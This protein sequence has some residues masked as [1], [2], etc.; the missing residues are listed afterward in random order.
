MLN[1]NEDLIYLGGIE[2]IER[3]KVERTA[4]NEY[5]MDSAIRDTSVIEKAE[6]LIREGAEPREAYEKAIKLCKQIAD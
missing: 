3:D 4:F 2:P 5:G 1:M 6:Q